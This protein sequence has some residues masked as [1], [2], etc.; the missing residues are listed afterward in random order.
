LD[1]YRSFED[2][3]VKSLLTKPFLIVGV[4]FMLRPCCSNKQHWEQV[5]FFAEDPNDMWEIWKK[6]FLEVLDN[7]APLQ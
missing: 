7:H 5:Y 3:Y 4:H 6:I 1:D 2:A